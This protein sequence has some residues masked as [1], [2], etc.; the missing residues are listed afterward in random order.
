MQ[1]L[2]SHSVRLTEWCFPNSY[3]LCLLFALLKSS[4][5]TVLKTTHC[6]KEKAFYLVLCYVCFVIANP[7]EN[8]LFFLLFM[9][10][11]PFLNLL[12]AGE[13]FQ[14]NNPQPTCS[15]EE[16]RAGTRTQGPWACTVCSVWVLLLTE[17]CPCPSVSACSLGCPVSS[18]THSMEAATPGTSA[19][20][21]TSSQTSAGQPQPHVC[22]DC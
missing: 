5:Y 20:L 11:P 15:L 3:D 6:R 9:L 22:L 10:Y 2:C 21:A 13:K 8:A 16:G 4:Q 1:R 14:A 12:S 19:H 18:G 7:G 17:M